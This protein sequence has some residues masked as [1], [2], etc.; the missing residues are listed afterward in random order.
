MKKKVPSQKQLQQPKSNSLAGLL[1]RKENINQE[2][3]QPKGGGNDDGN[4]LA[5]GEI[6]KVKVSKVKKP[7]MLLIKR[8]AIN[9]IISTGASNKEY[10]NESFEDNKSAEG[11]PQIEN[12]ADREIQPTGSLLQ[13]KT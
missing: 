13:A 3:G 8:S 11:R 2:A 5:G 12:I 1:D 6:Q 7:E 10:E 4:S 9:S